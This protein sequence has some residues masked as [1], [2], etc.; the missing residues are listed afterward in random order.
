MIVEMHFRSP[1]QNPYQ[2]SAESHVE[3]AMGNGVSMYWM[4]VQ[5]RVAGH[6]G[7]LDYET[8]LDDILWVLLVVISTFVLAGEIVLAVEPDLAQR[9]TSIS[10]CAHISKRGK[11]QRENGIASNIL[12]I[13][14]THLVSRASKLSSRRTGDR[15]RSLL[16]SSL[17]TSSLRGEN[18][19]GGVLALLRQPGP[20]RGGVR[21]LVRNGGGLLE[22]LLGGDLVRPPG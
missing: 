3:K 21:S 2:K 14:Q 18:L 8:V 10:V 1:C 5:R 7:E 20:S 11:E 16:L 15:G 9:A 4:L 6:R 12:P 19:R 22:R 13:P 17:R